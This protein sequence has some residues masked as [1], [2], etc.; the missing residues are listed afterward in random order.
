MAYTSHIPTS[1]L[2]SCDHFYFWVNGNFTALPKVA[3]DP[4]SIHE[5]YGPI[6][7]GQ[8]LHVLGCIIVLNSWIVF[9]YM[10]YLLLSLDYQILS[11]DAF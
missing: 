9:V 11:L 2:A 6:L 3:E 7:H 1:L 8:V 4:D 5:W 10:I